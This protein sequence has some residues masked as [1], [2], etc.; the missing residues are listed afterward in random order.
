MV[1][2][3]KM[4]KS[5]ISAATNLYPFQNHRFNI[6]KHNLDP[7][8]VKFK[9]KEKKMYKHHHNPDRMTRY[10]N[11]VNAAVKKTNNMQEPGE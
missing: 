8:E 10:N 5:H 2:I 6:L 9:F 1:I 3:K 7:E 11:R 4:V